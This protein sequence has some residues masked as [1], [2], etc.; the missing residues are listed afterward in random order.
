MGEELSN[1][2]SF[3]NGFDSE[4]CGETISN[5]ELIRTVH[6]SFSSPLSIIDEDKKNNPPR[7][8]D[9]KNDGLFH[10]IGYVKIN[11]FIYEL[12]G[13][14]RYPIKHVPCE[15]DEE[16]SIKLP[17]VIR[18]RVSLYGNEELRFSLLGIT[19]D[20]LKYFQDI[21]NYQGFSSEMLKRETW[22]RENELRKHDYTPLIMQ[23]L[24]NVGGELD[25]KE[26]EGLLND[27]S[28]RAQ[29][30]L[31]AAYSKR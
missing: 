12:D 28:K 20:R 14:K 21:G 4:L 1:F 25:D 30:K 23:V 3:V 8:D 22:K 6:N 27:G 13:L 17:E 29:A 18:Q 5:S 11:N 31:L 10:F 7:S 15:T 26:W 9:G 24:K 16:F 19:H 2:K